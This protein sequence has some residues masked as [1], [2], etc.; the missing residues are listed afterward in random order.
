[1]HVDLVLEDG[2]FIDGQGSQKPLDSAKLHGILRIRGADHGSRATPCESQF[3]QCPTDGLDANPDLVFFPK[4]LGKHRL[5]ARDTL[6]SLD[7]T[8]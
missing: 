2:D 8:V 1:M 4:H 6:P 7:R 3:V 5:V